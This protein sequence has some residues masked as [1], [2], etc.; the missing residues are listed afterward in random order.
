M[1][2]YELIF[3]MYQWPL[4]QPLYEFIAVRGIENWRQRVIPAGSAKAFRDRQQMQI[5]IAQ[6]G[7]CLIG[8]GSPGEA[9]PGENGRNTETFPP[10]TPPAEYLRR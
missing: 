9:R 10:P 4:A 5:V 1:N 6:H 7:D 3:G 8:H 2:H